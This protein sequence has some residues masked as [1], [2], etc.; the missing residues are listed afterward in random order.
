MNFSI[1]LYLIT[2]QTDF[3]KYYIKE[4]EK[5]VLEKLALIGLQKKDKI[6]T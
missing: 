5:N 3:I 1:C 6:S 2:Q 4:M